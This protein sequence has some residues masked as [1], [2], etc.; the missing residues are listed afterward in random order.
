MTTFEQDCQLL[1]KI[2]IINA[3]LSND[4]TLIKQ[5]GIVSMLEGVGQS[6]VGEVKAGFQERGWKVILDFL[7]PAIFKRF[8]GWPGAAIDLV[9]TGLGIHLDDYMISAF[10]WVKDQ[11][12]NLISSKGEVTKEDINSMTNGISAS[13]SLSA[14][15]EIEKQGQIVH[16][17][18]SYQIEKTAGILSPIWGFISY[19]FGM[20]SKKTA[21]ELIKGIIKWFIK[22][23]LLGIVGVTA[24]KHLLGPS[25]DTPNTNSPE[26]PKEQI[27]NQVPA[28]QSHS[29]NHSGQGAQF[30]TNAYDTAWVVKLVNDS[31]ADT[32]VAWAT[33]IYPQLAGHEDDIRKS[34]SF[35][36]MVSIL[37]RNYDDSK[38][39]YLEIIPDSGL[40]TWKDIVDRFVGDIRIN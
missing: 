12:T 17:L 3:G 40:H 16:I 27:L 29:L 1:D 36:N 24:A 32:L 20:G 11:I 30:H 25:Q 14:L 33:K 15:Y 8:F 28:A 23:V 9:L 38:P 7:S 4:P 39:S 35:N 2:M 6:I 19:V 22:A 18:Q 13:G 21:T 10:S 26:T 34:S 37:E 5:A 31:I